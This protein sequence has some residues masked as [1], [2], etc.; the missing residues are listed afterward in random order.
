MT[1]DIYIYYKHIRARKKLKRCVDSR[2]GWHGRKTGRCSCSFTATSSNWDGD[3]L[4]KYTPTDSESSNFSD[5]VTEV[6]ED[7]CT[8][9]IY[10]LGVR[11]PCPCPHSKCILS[12]LISCDLSRVDWGRI[13][14]ILFVLTWKGTRYYQ[15][16]MNKNFVIGRFLTY[17]VEPVLHNKPLHI[18]LSLLSKLYGVHWID[19]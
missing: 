17:S 1:I 15:L 5:K 3:A 19:K 18:W 13:V 9:C 6:N 16:T 12:R 4:P 14:P 7:R 11:C 10:E 8:C 2:I